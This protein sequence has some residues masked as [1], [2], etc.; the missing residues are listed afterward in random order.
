VK[1]TAVTNQASSPLL[2]TKFYRPR[3]AKDF[4]PRARLIEWLQA[5][6]HQP[7]ILVSAPAG[8]GK[9]TLIGHWLDESAYPSA[10]LSLDEHDNSLPVFV[11]YLVAAIQHAFPALEL[12]TRLM[13]NAPSLPPVMTLARSLIN[14]LEKLETPC[15][16]V[17]DDMHYIQELAVYELLEEWLRHPPRTMRLVL[18]TRVDPPLNLNRLRAKRQM[19]EI[20]LRDLSFTTSETAAFIDV[21]DGS[22]GRLQVKRRY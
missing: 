5:S 4:V 6:E 16:L 18:A 22:H 9:S 3:I 13:L 2:Q 20:R 19:I 1:N 15:V 14:D 12:K 21:V 17:L 10:W 11:N 8:Y 7:L